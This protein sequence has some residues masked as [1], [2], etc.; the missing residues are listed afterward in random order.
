MFQCYISVIRGKSNLYVLIRLCP[1][2]PG[3]LLKNTIQKKR[4]KT[5]DGRSPGE[6][7]YAEQKNSR[8]TVVNSQINRK[9]ENDHKEN[10]QK[11]I[12]ESK[13][14]GIP[15]CLPIRLTVAG[16]Q[17]KGIKKNR[18]NRKNHQPDRILKNPEDRVNDLINNIQIDTE[19]DKKAES[20]QP[21]QGR[22]GKIPPE[23]PK[24]ALDQIRIFF[25]YDFQRLTVK[26]CQRRAN[27]ENR[28]TCQDKNCI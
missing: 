13:L 2:A 25:S 23:F 6:K 21:E 27:R 18:G 26:S 1:V 22:S 20:R 11:E 7:E 14:N 15:D 19:E 17:R 5:G 8:D 9:E 28:K 24:I 4:E 16:R 3:D 10:G 12:S